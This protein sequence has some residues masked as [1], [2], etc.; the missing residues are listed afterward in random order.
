MEEHVAHVCI[1]GIHHK[2]D[3]DEVMPIVQ[4]SIE[5]YEIMDV[6][7]DGGNGINIISEQLWRKLGLRKPLSI[8]FMVRMVNQRKVQPVWLIQNLQIEL[9]RCTFKI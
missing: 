6:L 7:L 1:I 8:P 2:N 9:T 3:F 5:N 4:V